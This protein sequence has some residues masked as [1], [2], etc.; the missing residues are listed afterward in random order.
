MELIRVD[1]S[2]MI[3]DE[4]RQDQVIVLKEQ[5]GERKFPIMIGFN[6]ASS[7]KMSLSNFK[8]PRP[9]THDLILAIFDQLGAKPEKLIIDKIIEHTFH[10][11]LIVT[12]V[13]GE[14]KA[15]DLRPSDGVAIAVRAKI[16]MF[17]DEEVLKNTELPKI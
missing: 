1:L 15:I 3:I 4:K 8:V 2:K 5:Q 12:D 16:P 7:I 10:A 14:S 13:Q 9:M 11:K 17:V 6:E